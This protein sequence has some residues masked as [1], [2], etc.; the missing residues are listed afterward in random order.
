M[1]AKTNSRPPILGVSQYPWR[2]AWSFV[3]NWPLL[4]TACLEHVQHC[5]MS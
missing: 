4:C 1:K 3:H 2:S 5:A